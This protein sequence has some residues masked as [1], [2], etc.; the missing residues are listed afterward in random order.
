MSFQSCFPTYSTTNKFLQDYTVSARCLDEIDSAIKSENFNINE[1]IDSIRN[2][3]NVYNENMLRVVNL[4]EARPQQESESVAAQSA[5]ESRL[6]TESE[7]KARDEAHASLWFTKVKTSTFPQNH[8][9]SSNPDFVKIK[10]VIENTKTIEYAL[11]NRTPSTEEMDR[12]ILKTE[13]FF[14]QKED[15]AKIVQTGHALLKLKDKIIFTINLMKSNEQI[16]PHLPNIRPFTFPSGMTLP[17]E[18]STP[19]RL[20][21]ARTLPPTTT[22][23]HEKPATDQMVVPSGI[24]TSPLIIPKQELSSIDITV[25]HTFNPEQILGVCCDLNWDEPIPFIQ[26]ENGWKGQVPVNQEW[27]FVVLNKEG[28][29]VA[30]EKHKN[31]RCNPNTEPF[32]VKSNELRF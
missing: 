30:W 1:I 12:F 8:D 31:R 16:A 21:Q 11:F 19:P 22:I 4:L 17:P 2:V 15:S 23:S 18:L 29:I 28:K 24:N 14:K 7:I 5:C 25:C 9:F 10:K 20:R 3:V 6:F 13:W 32:T 26:N 27:K